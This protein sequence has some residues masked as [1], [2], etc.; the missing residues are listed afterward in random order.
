M[1]SNFGSTPSRMYIH[2]YDTSTWYSTYKH[3]TIGRLDTP[4]YE[5]GTILDHVLKNPRLTK[6]QTILMRS[7]LAK[8]FGIIGSVPRTL[9][10]PCDDTISDLQIDKMSRYDCREFVLRR[11]I[12]K[13]IVLTSKSSQQMQYNS[14]GEF[15]E[16]I[17]IIH[18]PQ[19]YF[20]NMHKIKQIDTIT[21]NGVY[22][23][24]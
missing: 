17:I 13:K 1:T 18:G 22:N 19:Y 8:Y 6:Y 14:D 4:S 7:G 10:I 21:D 15:P 24:Y 3:G 20:Y 9:F 12:R 16:K 2:S 11:M 23:I 5:D